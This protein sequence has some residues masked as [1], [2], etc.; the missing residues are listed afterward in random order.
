MPSSEELHEDYV[1]Q[2]NLAVAEDRHDLVDALTARFAA[3]STTQSP[4]ANPAP[5]DRLRRRCR[6]EQRTRSRSLLALVIL[7]TVV[8]GL[9]QA[10]FT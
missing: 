7:F 10:F 5:L 2:V 1:E 9:V 4:D 8:T 6:H 3:T